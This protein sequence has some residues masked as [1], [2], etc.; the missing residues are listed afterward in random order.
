M[1]D[2]DSEAIGFRAA[3]E[4]FARF[5][6]FKTSDL[7]TIWHLAGRRVCLCRE[8][9]RGRL[10]L[11]GL[12]CGE[13]VALSPGGAGRAAT[14]PPGAAASAAT[15]PA[16]PIPPR[17]Y[18]N[19]AALDG[20]NSAGV[21]RVP[22]AVALS[23]RAVGA[24]IPAIHRRRCVNEP[25]TTAPAPQAPRNLPKRRS[26]PLERCLSLNGKNRQSPET[27]KAAE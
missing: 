1:P 7:E 6:R 4:S 14:S 9:R 15:G 24:R 10:P 27:T 17:R 8:L 2:L 21:G 22:T 12:R 16:G 26:A 23:D 3:S 13:V 19:F 18:A 5:R 11:P 25:T 20:A